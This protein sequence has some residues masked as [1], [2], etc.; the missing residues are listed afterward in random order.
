MYE[1]T[2]ALL[3]GQP[4]VFLDYDLVIII[5]FFFL[6]FSVCYLTRNARYYL[7]A[8]RYL[9]LETDRLQNVFCSTTKSAQ[10]HL[11]TW[12]AR[13]PIRVIIVCTR[14]CA[15][16]T[17]FDKGF[18]ITKVRTNTIH[19]DK[20]MKPK[21]T[22]RT[23]KKNRLNNQTWFFYVQTLLVIKKEKKW[24]ITL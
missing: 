23:K 7:S 22:A 14:A 9:F 15:R 2:H 12:L 4:R 20:I 11:C 8:I 13:E 18:S 6:C 24:R 17:G 10:V 5:F 1:D 3:L 19:L 16:R 21:S